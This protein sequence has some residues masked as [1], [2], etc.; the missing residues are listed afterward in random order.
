MAEDDP[1][2]W[3][4]NTPSERTQD[5]EAF[6]PSD[7]EAGIEV[8][9]DFKRFEQR[10]DM[11]SRSQ[12]DEAIQTKAAMEFWHGHRKPKPRKGD[13]FRQR[14]FALRNASWVMASS[15]MERGFSDGLREGFTDDIQAFHPPDPIKIEVDDPVEMTR[16][17]K[18]VSK[19]FGAD[20]VGITE[21]DERWVYTSKFN[22]K[23]KEQAP[24]EL[25]DGLTSVIMVGHAMEYDIIK[26]MP[27][28]LASTAVGKG[29]STEAAIVMHI[30]QYIRNLG[31]EAVGSM[32]DTSLTIPQAIKAGLGEY[33]RH[34][35]LI[36]KEFGPRV[37]VSKIFTNLPLT[38]DKPEKFGVTEFCDI[39]RRCYEACPV[40]AIT[41]GPPTDTGQNQSSLKG[42]VKWTTDCEKCF[43]YWTALRTDCAICMRVC[44]YNKDFSKWYMK[45]ARWLAGTRLRR[46][47]LW[48]DIK[49]GYGERDAPQKWWSGGYQK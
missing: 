31:Y 10:N 47:M 18:Q 29:Y 11:F 26:S 30:A 22:I 2:G 35:M 28:A 19:Y 41:D 34:N 7:A 48:L 32:N 44:P 45:L 20:L 37:R 46:F 21:F 4:A 8:K 40:D 33:G 27:S 39:C 16:E 23:T 24:V 15:I 13:G 3:P 36:T 17:I 38:H 5:W 42:V 12:W 1:S 49:L 25:P 14:D 6:K 43:G 9:D